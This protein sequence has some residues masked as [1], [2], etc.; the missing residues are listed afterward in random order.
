MKKSRR[1]IGQFSIIAALLVSIILVTAVIIT[2]STIR[3]NPSQESPK[4]LTSIG[5]MNL[6]IKSILEFTV[7]YYGS[8]LQVTGNW[9]YAQQ[10]ASS[11]LQSGLVNIADSHPDWNPSFKVNSSITGVSTRWF[12]PVS[13]SMGNIS[14]TYSMSGL[15]IKGVNYKTSSLLKATFLRPINNGE[16][17]FVVTQEGNEPELGLSKENFFFYNYSYSKSTWILVNPVSNPVAFSN[18]TYV[19]QIPSG[20]DTTAYSIQ[21]ADPRAI[22]VTAF[23]SG[24]SLASGIPQYS[25]TFTWNSSLYSSLTRDTLVV[26]A[27]QNST[28]RWLGQNLFNGKPIPPIPV[29]ALHVNETVNGVSREVPFQVEDWGS[30]YRVPLGLTSNASVSSSR[31]MIVFLVNHNVQMA[32]FWWDGRDA[33]K[34]TSYAWKNRYFTG[35]NPVVP[36]GV[37][38]NG[39]LNLTIDNSG[40]NFV[41][42]S[43]VGASSSSAQFLRIDN[44]NPTYGSDPSYVIHHGIV[45]DIVQEEAEWSGGIT[46]CPN[47]YSQIYLTLPANATYY[48]YATRLIFINSS[49]SRTITNLSAIKLSVSGGSLSPRTENGTSGGYPISSSGTG[50]FYNFTSPS[51]QTGWAHHWS[52]FISGSS[53]AGIMFTDDSNTKLYTFD[54]IAGQKTGALNVT[55][56]GSHIE[57]NPVSRQYQASFRYPLDVTWHGAVVTFN[58]DPMNTIYNTSSKI[59]LRV[60]IENPPKILIPPNNVFITVT[61]GL[62]GSGYVKVDGNNITTPTTFNWT[63]GSSHTLQVLSPVAGSAGTQYVCTGWSD[64]GAQNHTYIVPVSNATITANWQT[65]Y[66]VTFNYQVSGGGSGYSAPSINY[67][68]LGSQN[69]VTA[70]SSAVWV[71]SGSTYTYTNNPLIGSGASERWYA[72]SGASGTISS[73]TT[74]NPT[75][76]NQYYLTVSSAYGNPTGQGWYNVGSSASFGVTTPASGGA[77]IQ[78]VFTSWSGS[79]SGSYSGKSSSSSVTMNNAI[80]ET[81]QWKTQYQLTMVTNFG[82]TSPAAGSTWYNASSVVTISATAPSAGAGER[83]V[84][85][86]WTGSGNGSYTGTNNPATVTMNGPV[87][88]TASWAHQWQVTFQQTGLGSDASGTVLTVGTNTYNYSQLPLT[89]I[90]VNNGTAYSYSSTVSAGT[91]RYV[92]TGVTGVSSPVSASGTV[93]ATY[94]TQ[95]FGIDAK[96]IGFGSESSSGSSPITTSNMTAQANELIIVVVTSGHIGSSSTRTFTVTDSFGNT[97]TQRG[98]TVSSGLNAEQISVYYWNTTSHTGVFTVTVTPNNYNRNMTVLAFGI[99]GAASFDTYSTLPKSASNTGTSTTPT[100]SS[101]YTSNPND[102]VLAFEGHLSSTTENASSP[103]QSNSSLLKNANGEG[104]AVEYEIVTSQLNNASVQFGRQVSNWVM[105]VDAVRRA[106]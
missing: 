1:N 48:T 42:T 100:V 101:V 32:T 7:G 37:L 99:T 36:T 22:A 105:I 2:Y 88:E 98:S 13:Y 17:R 25:Y 18:G 57:F 62:S 82:T 31:N 91:K 92:L 66:Q 73:S 43:H 33:A 38:T 4:V 28:L 79:G 75:Y 71:D 93:T 95:T 89:G 103:F 24:D 106:W 29:K 83:Y 27:L 58:N 35:D 90:W 20:V 70:N 87:T 23:Y 8:I 97:Y 16:A 80:T 94:K 56:S 85:N 72:S 67:T 19:L 49:Q 51:F 3:N 78:Y 39:I 30:N 81:A 50:I 65:Q 14:V 9:T 74:I 10:R 52:E 47:V 44:K 53:G 12:M 60:M 84:W 104:C 55:S 6:A 5:E 21:V 63:K 46:N 77:G 102:I 45:R 64:G 59:G 54:S 86:G 34:Q 15:G 76:Y 41:I 26:E 96:C 40:N 11:Y 69:S 68:S 61:S